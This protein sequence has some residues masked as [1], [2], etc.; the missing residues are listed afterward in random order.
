MLE[1]LTPLNKCERVSR[2]VDPVTFTAVPGVW[3]QV[4]SDGSLLNVL[5]TVNALINKLVIGS[6]SSN[7][8]ESNDVEV[9]RIT[10]LESI[11]VRCKVG[12]E[13]FTGFP[14]Q[15]DFMTVSSNLNTLGKLISIGAAYDGTYEV[16]ARCEEVNIAGGYIIFRTISPYIAVSTV[17]LS[18]SPSS[19]ASSSASPSA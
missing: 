3:A 16:V 15:G 4:Q 9:G 2:Q 13:G 1:I 5:S 6:A 12:T 8:Y 7:V 10:T 11:G 17:S 14:T 18:L 19:S